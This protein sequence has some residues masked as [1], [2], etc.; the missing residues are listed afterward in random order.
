MGRVYDILDKEGYTPEAL[1]DNSLDH[2]GLAQLTGLLN[3]PVLSMQTFSCNWCKKVKVK[4][5]AFRK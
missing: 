5:Q 1:A 4:K 2:A 3:G